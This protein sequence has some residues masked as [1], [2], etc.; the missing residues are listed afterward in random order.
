M[1]MSVHP[2]LPTGTVSEAL[3]VIRNKRRRTLLNV[4]IV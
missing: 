2:R 3:D 4:Q 1:G